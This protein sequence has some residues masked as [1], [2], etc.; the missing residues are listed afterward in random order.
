MTGHSK[1]AEQ[2]IA[3]LGGKGMLGSD[4]FAACQ[5]HGFDAI[6]LDLPNF[7]IT[8]A[9]HLRQ[10]VGE[11][12]IIVNCAAYT[13][14]EKAES[15]TELAYKVNAEAVGKLGSVAK[16]AGIWVLHIS[17]DF[18]FDGTSDRPYV[19]TDTPNPINVY[20]A[21]KLASEKL[22]IESGCSNCI[23]RIEWTYGLNGD[24]FV[25]KLI[26]KAK[27]NKEISVVDDQIGS[28]TATTEVAEAICSLVQKKPEGLFHFAASGYASRFEA[29]KFIFDR[30]K[31]QVNLTNC[32]TSGY[33]TAAK[34][35]L[36]SRFCCDKIQSL[37]AEP[38]KPWQKP[39]E[40]FLG[41]I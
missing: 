9:G 22:L 17:T 16:N 6:A 12:K 15:E 7:D 29:A 41:Q 37:L 35:P 10:V 27:S 20:G 30:L 25:I 19:E 39:L 18:V 3:I 24:N 38:I 32:K 11:A 14:V 13:N 28:P 1:M 8:N 4:V 34:R 21:S 26:N 40:K 2:K 36:N 5:K 31:M 33:K 23:M